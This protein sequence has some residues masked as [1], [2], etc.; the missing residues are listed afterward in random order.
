MNFGDRRRPPF[1][2]T[3]SIPR[4]VVLSLYLE[5]ISNGFLLKRIQKKKKKRKQ[6]ETRDYFSVPQELTK[7]LERCLQSED[8][9]PV[10]PIPELS[11]S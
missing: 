5:G 6:K 1:D 9:F 2:L 11:P 7:S 4:V 8:R 3:Y 10:L